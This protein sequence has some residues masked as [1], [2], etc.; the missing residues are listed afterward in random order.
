MSKDPADEYRPK[1][2]RLTKNAEMVQLLLALSKDPSGAHDKSDFA[3]K[4]LKQKMRLKED[5]S[6]FV[7]PYLAEYLQSDCQMLERDKT[8]S[9]R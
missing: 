4:Y 7:R 2:F 8:M 3:S 6:L 9:G 1:V 5:Q